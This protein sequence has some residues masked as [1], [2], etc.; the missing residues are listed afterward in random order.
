MGGGRLHIL[1]RAHKVMNLMRLLSGRMNSFGN[2]FVSKLHLHEE[3]ELYHKHK[4]NQLLMSLKVEP[5]MANLNGTLH[6]GAIATIIDVSTTIA[7]MSMDKKDRAN[8][9]AELNMSF[10]SAAPIGEDIF[11]LSQVDRIGKNVAFTQCWIFNNMHDTLVSGR[12]IKAFLDQKFSLDG[13]L[14]Y[15]KKE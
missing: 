4:H 2:Q 1:E 7:V 10:L 11:V 8:V 6:G 14:L 12:H 9:S 3:H 13:E 15:P 5:S